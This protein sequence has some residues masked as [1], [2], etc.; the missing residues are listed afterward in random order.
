MHAN[1]LPDLPLAEQPESILLWEKLI[2]AESGPH[3]SGK[4]MVCGHTMEA[5]AA[6]SW[7]WVMQ[8]ALTRL[9]MPAAG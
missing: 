9:P 5:K 7:T 6:N 4:I 2:P 3:V 1:V 8:F